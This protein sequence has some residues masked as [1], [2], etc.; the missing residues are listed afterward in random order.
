MDYERHLDIIRSKLEE[1]LLKKNI[2]M[3]NPVVCVIETVLGEYILGWNG[4]VPKGGP[5][6][7]RCIREECEIKGIRHPPTVHAEI[8]G[9]YNAAKE[10]KS[11][12]GAK[13]FMNKWFPCFKPCSV[14][15][16][17]AEIA[18]VW[19][20][21]EVYEDVANHV[22]VEGLRINEYHDFIEAE[23]LLRTNNVKIMVEPRIR[24]FY[25]S[26]IL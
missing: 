15:I 1:A 11:V 22:L 3:Q 12:K 21:E 17:E 10:G 19:T 5:R 6:H 24:P 26:P 4:P 25:S 16:V 2:C 23:K 13:I 18:E 20:P 14:A 8:S 7:E 9:I